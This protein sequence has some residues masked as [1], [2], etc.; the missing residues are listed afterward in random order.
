MFEQRNWGNPTTNNIGMKFEG[1][2]GDVFGY[3]GHVT[4][5][6]DL[7]GLTRSLCTLSLPVE[8]IRKMWWQNNLNSKYLHMS[9]T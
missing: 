4:D 8:E 5:D 6:P 1:K 9:I 2:D 7:R 3:F